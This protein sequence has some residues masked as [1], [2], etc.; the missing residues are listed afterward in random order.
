MAQSGYT[1]LVLYTSTTA[2]HVPTTGNLAVGELAINIPDGKLY[3]N[4]SGTITILATD[5]TATGNIP[6][7]V[8]NEVVYQT[9][10]GATSFITAPTA[11]NQALI[12]NGSAFV[13]EITP[14]ATSLVTANFSIQQASGKL[15]FYYGA[16]QI[17]S[18]DSS[19]NFTALTNVTAYGTP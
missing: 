14:S 7:G 17:A 18:L 6:G 1:P 15:Y 13:W 19:G 9:G 5:T 10:V 12:W 16:T 2:G 4:K 11:T 3:Y 8:A